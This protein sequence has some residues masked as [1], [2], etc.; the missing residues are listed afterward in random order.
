MKYFHLKYVLFMSGLLLNVALAQAENVHED[1]KAARATD[2]RILS[3]QTGHDEGLIEDQLKIQEEFGRYTSRLK[4]QYPNQIS[5]VW[6]DPIPN[7][8]GHVRFV[9][10]IPQEIKDIGA[11]GEG[12]KST[13]PVTYSIDYI[14]DGLISAEG[15]EARKMSAAK[16]LKELGYTNHVIYYSPKEN[17]LVATINYQGSRPNK[18]AVRSKIHG[19]FQKHI[20]SRSRRDRV[21]NLAESD[22]RIEMEESDEPIIK[23]KSARGGN[24]IYR[25]YNEQP[26]GEF[27]TS[28]WPVIHDTYGVG[29]LTA[30]HCYNFD[31]LIEEDYTNDDMT[32]KVNLRWSNHDVAFYTMSSDVDP[33]FYADQGVIRSVEGYENNIVSGSSVCFYGRTS[34]SRTCTNTVSA[35]N[36]S[37]SFVQYNQNWIFNNLVLVAFNGTTTLLGGD[38]GGGWSVGTTAWGTSTGTNNQVTNGYFTP[39]TVAVD[40]LDVELYVDGTSIANYFEIQTNN[41]KCLTYGIITNNVFQYTCGQNLNDTG[42]DFYFAKNGQ[43]KTVGGY[44]IAAENSLS[45]GSDLRRTSC[46]TSDAKQRWF[47]ESAE[48]TYGR[49]KAVSNSNLCFDLQN[50][51]SGDGVNVRLWSCN[52][53]SAQNWALVTQSNT[54]FKQVKNAS[55]KCLD[56]NGGNMRQGEI[57]HLWTCN[58]QLNQKWIVTN[59]GVFRTI[60]GMCLDAGAVNP[61]S[62]QDIHLW[63][64]DTDYASTEPDQR[65]WSQWW[66]NVGGGFNYITTDANSSLCMDNENG[67]TSNGTDIQVYTCNTS[68]AQ[69]W[70][71]ISWPY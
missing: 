70:D 35:T 71:V 33:E 68:D 32:E 14:S 64:C 5:G 8:K 48:S 10:D 67:G 17:K 54:S 30:G 62:G 29:I 42:Q 51:S 15:H 23:L 34:N 63:A 24:R 37:S 13:S 26:I 69:D 57:V 4:S 11:A 21:R 28:G 55:G 6:L 60:N 2:I 47:L 36:V 12:I 16:E 61:S 43:I 19:R 50:N 38:S 58:N 59:S 39:L 56:V 41:G 49:F 65:R 9:G 46:N 31:T 40:N 22:I 53:T 25:Y 44:C 66:S 18:S 3:E 52:G 27:C 1:S 7:T 20:A 45:S